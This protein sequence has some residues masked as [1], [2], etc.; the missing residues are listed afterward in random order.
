MYTVDC[1]GVGT[2][3]SNNG[4]LSSP[5]ISRPNPVHRFSLFVVNC[6]S[7]QIEVT[8]VSMRVGRLEKRLHRSWVVVV[9]DDLSSLENKSFF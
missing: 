2:R 3:Y 1:V 4:R 6:H 5:S 7:R 9:G 8:A